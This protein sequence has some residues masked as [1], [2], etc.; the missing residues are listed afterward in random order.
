MFL[1]KLSEEKGKMF[2]QLSI[3]AA[4][5]N[6]SLAEEEKSLINSYCD[7]LGIK[8]YEPKITT[9]LNT[10]LEKIKVNTTEEEKNIIVFEIVGLII[11]DNDYDDKEKE[12]VKT[13]KEKLGI[14]DDKLNKMFEAVRRLMDVYK[15]ISEVIMS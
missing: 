11:S 10:L 13:L 12:F 7:E 5:A 6:N 9:D 8:E 2:L 4:L 14:S 1:G 3:H 15:D